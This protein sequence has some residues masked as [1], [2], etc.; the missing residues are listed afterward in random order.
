MALWRIRRT[1]AVSRPVPNVA[2]I[3]APITSLT[4]ADVLKLRRRVVVSHH[5][6]SVYVSAW[7]KLR[8]KPKS[9]LQQAWV[10]QFSLLARALKSPP[11]STLDAATAWAKGTGWYYRDV[12]EVA[13]R[14][15]LTRFRGETPITTPTC[16]VYR[17]AAESL[18]S[19]VQK[20]LT[21]NS[22]KW[23]NNVFWD[24]SLN[25]S[26]ITFKSAGLYL[27]IA[28]LSWNSGSSGYRYANI[29][30]NGSESIA[31]EQFNAAGS[32]GNESTVLGFNYFHA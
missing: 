24:S 30:R 28:Y 6:G 12:L 19:G 4:R 16:F 11:P 13:A 17:S 25:P 21:P 2:R 23:D 31:S 10:D 7:P 29:Y 8:G 9:K 15:K 3:N 22:R 20:T 18:S 27:I 14:G 32:L 26:R 1:S 5:R